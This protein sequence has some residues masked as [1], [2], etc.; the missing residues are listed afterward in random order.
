MFSPTGRWDTQE[1]VL[2][3]C[4]TAMMLLALANG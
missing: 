2:L 1:L 4:A 3:A